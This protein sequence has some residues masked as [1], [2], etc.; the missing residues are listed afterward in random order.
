MYILKLVMS[1]ILS[2][3]LIINDISVWFK[4]KEKVLYWWTL[5]I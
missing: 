4:K 5:D 3:F 2:T 1:V